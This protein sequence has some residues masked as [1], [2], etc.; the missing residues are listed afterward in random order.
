MVSAGLAEPQERGSLV[1]CDS[2]AAVAGAGD[3]PLQIVWLAAAANAS[4]QLGKPEPEASGARR[5]QDLP[6]LD[7]YTLRFTYLAAHA[8]LAVAPAA[9]PSTGGTLLMLTGALF[10]STPQLACRL[11]LDGLAPPAS[12]V[13]PR[14]VQVPAAFVSPELLRCTAPGVPLGLS[15]VAGQ[16]AAPPL[17]WLLDVTM[18]GTEFGPQRL[19]LPVFELPDV[20]QA[21][22]DSGSRSGGTVVYVHGGSFATNAPAPRCRFGASAPVM[23]AVLSPMVI[24]CI[25]PPFASEQRVS[26]SVSLNLVDW[27]AG[28]NATFTYTDRAIVYAMGAACGPDAGRHGVVIAGANFAARVHRYCRF[29]LAVP[30]MD[31]AGVVPAIVRSPAEVECISPAKG[32][33]ARRRCTSSRC[34]PLLTRG[35]RRPRQPCRLAA[36]L[37]QCTRQAACCLTTCRSCDSTLCCRP[38]CLLLAAWT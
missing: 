19:A 18:Q 38:R 12:D 29:A 33:W 13:A 34:R 22:P 2:P 17:R 30:S 14:C 20:L 1:A 37:T 25:S 9:V 6:R 27:H 21:E 23:A 16:L 36:I 35:C 31:A 3:V 15:D 7:A 10:S 4:I 8:L 26:I 32:A 5:A 11:C 24:R 28:A